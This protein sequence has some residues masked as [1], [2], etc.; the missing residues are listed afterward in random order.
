MRI[1]LH[2]LNTS[3]ILKNFK[4]QPFYIGFKIV[5][6]CMID[7]MKFVGIISIMTKSAL[8]FCACFSVHS[9]WV[10]LKALQGSLS[11]EVIS[12]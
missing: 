1:V 12:S 11:V 7:N 6:K 8:N 3:D 5:G 2:A 9:I 4:T 10:H